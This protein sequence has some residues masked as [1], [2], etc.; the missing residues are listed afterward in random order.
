MSFFR[1]G[2]WGGGVTGKLCHAASP[3]SS[4]LTF[5]F[6]AL[7]MKKER[8]CLKIPTHTLQTASSARI[9]PSQA[10]V[11]H[12]QEAYELRDGDI[13]QCS[14]VARTA[15]ACRARPPGSDGKIT[16]S[17]NSSSCSQTLLCS[18]STSSHPRLLQAPLWSSHF[19]L[20]WCRAKNHILAG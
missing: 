17:D 20:C 16:R 1:E 19:S 3:H 7:A 6:P 8:K 2:G 5:I 4:C 12:K 11:S 9:S 18:R 15:P 13:P 10:I 14:A